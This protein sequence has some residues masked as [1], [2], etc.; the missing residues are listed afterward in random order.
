MLAAYFDVLREFEVE[1]VT[2]VLSDWPKTQPKSP[3]AAELYKLLNDHAITGRE[4]QAERDRAEFAQGYR[5]MGASPAG[6]AALKELARICQ[7]RPRMT[8][9]TIAFGIMDKWCDGIRPNFISMKY[10][11]DAG[12]PKEKV[13]DILHMIEQNRA[14]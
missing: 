10:V 6:K 8:M 14:A 9:Q 11:L 12:I 1:K 2:Q 7:D 3:T 5:K 4:R 13:D